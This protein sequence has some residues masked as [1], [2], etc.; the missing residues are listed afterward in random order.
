MWGACS[1]VTRVQSG[2]TTCTGSDGSTTAVL[3]LCGVQPAIS[4]T[5]VATGCGG[6]GA[7]GGGGGDSADADSDSSSSGGFSMLWIGVSVGGGVALII[8]SSLLAYFC[9]F[10][11]LSAVKQLQPVSEPDLQTPAD[12]VAE[13]ATDASV[14]VAVAAPVPPVADGVQW[15]ERVPI[16]AAVV[17]PT[18]FAFATAAIQPVTLQQQSDAVQLDQI[19][20]SVG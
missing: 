18:K 1:C 4:Q 2:A 12:A 11:R 3:D 14:P 9:H 17:V 10:K 19:S 7:A 5:C 8:L 13:I 15:A 20:V 6:N 16:G